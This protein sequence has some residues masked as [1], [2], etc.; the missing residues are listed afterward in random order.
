MTENVRR[1]TSSLKADTSSYFTSSCLYAKQERH[2]A[3]ES[4]GENPTEYF[5]Y[6]H[7]YW[8]FKFLLIY[9]S[10]ISTESHYHHWFLWKELKCLKNF[11]LKIFREC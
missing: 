3:G 4:S 2:V 9:M 7:S 1:V 8:D 5:N 11:Y 6:L 10:L